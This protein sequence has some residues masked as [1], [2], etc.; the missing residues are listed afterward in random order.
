MA[1]L[2]I[3]KIKVSSQYVL[4]YVI[5]ILY[6]I[7]QELF[8][9]VFFYLFFLSGPYFDDVILTIKYFKSTIDDFISDIIGVGNIMTGNH[10]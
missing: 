5:S 8:K 10:I 7:S 1:T 3:A 2:D 9:N 4:T 6:S